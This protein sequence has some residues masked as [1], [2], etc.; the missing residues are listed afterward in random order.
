[1]FLKAAADG[2]IYV[3]VESRIELPNGDIA[4]TAT[5]SSS[6]TCK[7]FSITTSGTKVEPEAATKEKSPRGACVLVRP[8]PEHGYFARSSPDVSRADVLVLVAPGVALRLGWRREMTPE[9]P[10]YDNGRLSVRRT[11]S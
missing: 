4:F 2:K 8:R 11:S 1:M 9:F 6:R 10:P 7:V 5:A 3:A